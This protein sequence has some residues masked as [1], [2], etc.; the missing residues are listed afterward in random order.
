MADAGH[1]W[2][3]EQLLKLEKRVKREYARAYHELRGK[4]LE[5]LK[6]YDKENRKWLDDLK[7]G[8]VTKAAYKSWLKDQAV[9]RAWSND[10]MSKAYR[11][12]TTTVQKVAGMVNDV[13]PGVYAENANH[14]AYAID[15]ATNLD[16]GFAL[17]DES[18]VQR[19]LLE[20]PDLL[21]VRSPDPAKVASH[22]SAKVRSEVT[23]G[24]LQGESMQ[25][26]A[27][28]LETVVG[29]E[30]GASIRAARTAVTGAENAGRA[31]TYRRAEGMGIELR[32]EW[33]A[34]FDSRTRPSH[35]E[36][37]GQV[38]A[39]GEKFKVGA[40][41]L[42][43]PGDPTGSAG[44]IY[45]CRCTTAA[46][47]EGVEPL[48]YK[49]FG[50]LKREGLT[51]DEWKAGK[52]PPKKTKKAGAPEPTRGHAVVEGRDILGS[53]RRRPDEFDFEIE[54]VLDAQGFDGKPRVVDADEF[55]KAAKAANGGNGLVMQR[56]YSAPD[57]ETLDSYRDM[58]YDG[59]WYVDCSNGGAAYG[60]GMY[61]V[62]SESTGITQS[63]EDA[64]RHYT[65]G[66]E[67]SYVET[68]TLDPSAKVVKYDDLMLMKRDKALLDEF[69]SAVDV[70]DST[71]AFNRRFE[72]KT[73]G[74][75]ELAALLG[76]DAIIVP[77]IG[78][79]VVLNRTK[80]IIRRP[81]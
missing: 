3:D 38:I 45:N 17:Y 26:I 72:Y 64:M 19:L 1:D 73:L 48:A 66:S 67:C 60:R 65:R 56:A 35:R 42:G 52:M 58:L 9:Y 43:Y 8:R 80:L 13:L 68:M 10:M 36:A 29:M 69:M 55:D 77:D 20:E 28:R 74:E 7:D 5:W 21:P 57:Q 47:V 23:Q 34:T 25:R 49:D 2:T 79:S 62:Y 31:D 14:A 53:W 40:D 44:E 24:I 61:T 22:F 41:L 39:I 30:Q 70:S 37:H 11:D 78:Y 33:I 54:D 81:E 75:G 18:T 51:Y 59:K 63:M 32:Q 6:D 12:M 16:T 46:V 76:Y 4:R 27:E 71:E 50:K 15:S